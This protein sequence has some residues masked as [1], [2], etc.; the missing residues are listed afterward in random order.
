MLC[1]GKRIAFAETVKYDRRVVVKFQAN[2]WC[3]ET[4]MK[5]WIKNCW[6][7]ACEEN[8]HLVLDVHRAQATE[9][10]KRLLGEECYTD[11]TYVPG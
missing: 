1:V 10:V 3:D 9:A 4:I 7:P 6:K 2:A 5:F 11:V 8:M